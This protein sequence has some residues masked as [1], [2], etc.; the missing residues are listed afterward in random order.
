MLIKASEVKS[1]YQK[2]KDIDEK[3]LTR[4]LSVIETAIR[5]HTHNKFQNT[6]FRLQTNVIN[7]KINW[8]T[9]YLKVD[10]TIEIS[11]GPNKGLYTITSIADGFIE[12]DKPLF[13]YPMQL[14]TKIEY[15]LDIIEGAIDILDWELL[16]KGKE[17]TGVASE[18]ISR[19]SKTYNQRTK[20]NT[21][22]GYP[23]ELFNFCEDYECMRS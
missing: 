3:L 22:K 16:Q 5:E 23:V 20:E 14:I 1:L 7:G 10:D 21:I 9:D 12:V 11:D 15:P 6:F 19:H 17:K 2:F 13:D 8:N 18:T 4:K